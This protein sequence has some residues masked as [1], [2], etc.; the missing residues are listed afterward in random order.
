MARV[1]TG[2]GGYQD[3]LVALG[4]ILLAI[5][6]FLE[7]VDLLIFRTSTMPPLCAFVL[8]LHALSCSRRD[9]PLLG[10]SEVTLSSIAQDA[11]VPRVGCEDFQPLDSPLSTQ[12]CH[13]PSCGSLALKL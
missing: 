2:L 9:P 10:P 8:F 12:Q 3:F 13:Y 1:A 5:S 4:T 11:Q 7:P 6:Q